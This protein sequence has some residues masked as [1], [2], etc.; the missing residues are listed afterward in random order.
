V[1]G[2]AV[3]LNGKYQQVFVRT[4]KGVFTRKTVDVVSGNPQ[5]VSIA[6]GL[7][8]GDDVVVDGALYLE[9]LLEDAHATGN[10][11]TSADRQPTSSAGS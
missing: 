8:T 10:T 6:R 5:R 9:K 4:A 3:F 7:N 11:A 1:P 2:K